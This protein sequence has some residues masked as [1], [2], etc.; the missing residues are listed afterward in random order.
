M[1][2]ANFMRKEYTHIGRKPEKPKIPSKPIYWATIFLDTEIIKKPKR[3]AIVLFAL[4][5][6]MDIS[7]LTFEEVF[8]KRC[9]PKTLPT[10]LYDECVSITKISSLLGHADTATTWHYIRKNNPDEDT[11]N[12][13]KSLLDWRKIFTNIYKQNLYVM[14]IGETL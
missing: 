11:I 5:N 3:L 14:K 9:M 8:R 6:A 12:A 4:P 1:P 2:T 13:M 7:N 10:L